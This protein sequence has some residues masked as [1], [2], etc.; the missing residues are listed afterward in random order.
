MALIHLGINGQFPCPTI[1]AYV[2]DQIIVNVTNLS[3]EPTTIHW[4]GMLQKGSKIIIIISF[5]IDCYCS[6]FYHYHFH[7][8]WKSNNSQCY[9]PL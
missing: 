5:L 3:D 7:L 8:C 1:T 6:V 4:H 2:G 9:K